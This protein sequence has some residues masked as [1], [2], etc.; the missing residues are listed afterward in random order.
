MAYQISRRAALALGALA[1][2]GAIARAAN[3]V[4]F[5]VPLTGQQ[6][7]PPVQTN[8]SGT[9]NLTYNP[10][11]RLVTWDITYQNLSSPV[12]MAHFHGPAPEGKNAGVL[13]WL[14]QKG[15]PVSS[16]IRGSTTLSPDDAKMFMAGDMYINVHTKDHPAGEIRGQVKPPQTS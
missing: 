15:E 1:S 9:A 4:S 11:I 8:G 14:S 5:T 2:T 10:D 12:T 6:Q 3:P 7:V 13:I 16:P